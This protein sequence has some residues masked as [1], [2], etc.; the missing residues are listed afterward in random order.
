MTVKVMAE[1]EIDIDVIKHKL[2]PLQLMDIFTAGVNKLADSDVAP[3]PRRAFAEAF[4]RGLSENAKRMLAEAFAAEF[5][6]QTL[7][8]PEFP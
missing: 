1:V 2:S 6:H 7:S 4:R 8:V 3:Q 5:I